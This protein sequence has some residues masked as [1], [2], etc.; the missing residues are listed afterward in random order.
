MILRL[1]AHGVVFEHFHSELFQK[2]PDMFAQLN[3][4]QRKRHLR[5]KT[6]NSMR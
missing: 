3:E 6:E 1:R 2:A 4:N 5:T